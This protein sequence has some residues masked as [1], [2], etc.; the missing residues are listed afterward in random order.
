[1]LFLISIVIGIAG[2]IFSW[3]F[4]LLIGFIHNIA[5]S[6]EL[7]AVYDANIHTEGSYLG[8]LIIFAPVL[9][10]LVVVYLIKNYAPEAK[11]HGVPEVMHSIYHNR[12]LIPANVS[13]IKALASSITIGTG[14]SL[15]REGPIVQISAALSSYIGKLAKLSVSQRNLMI[16][17]GAS[18]GIAATFN[19]PLAGVLFSIELLLVAIN[20]RTIL[21]VAVATVIASNVGQY[22]IGDEPAFSIPEML[23]V[24]SG[25]G[26]YVS[27][28]AIPLG[29]IIGL[30]A[31]LFIKSIYYFED[32]FEKLPVND[33]ARHA[34]GTLLLGIM[35]Y[36]IYLRAGHYYIQGVGYATIQD[37][38]LDVI[39]D[40]GFMLLLIVTKLMATSLTI[41]S[42]GSG[43]VFSPSLFLG[44]VTGGLFGHVVNLL[45]PEL[46]LNPIVFVISGMAAMVSGTTSAPLTATIIVYEMTMDYDTILP[47]L[48]A[49]SIA[50]VVRRYFMTGDIYTLKLNR[51]GQMIPEEL[52]ADLKSHIIIDDAASKNIVFVTENEYVSWENDYACIVS[53]DKVIEIV[54]LTSQNI[55]REVPVSLLKRRKFIVLKA[56]T[57]AGK[58]V[59]Q[60][61]MSMCDVALV[62]VTGSTDKASVVGVVSSSHLINAIGDVTKTLR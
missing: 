15:G 52:V 26:V 32:L 28:L 33:Y 4:R 55:E 44:A 31:L 59:M 38:L 17:C 43:G 37:V 5:F 48:T 14:G 62:S 13:I 47:V 39:T 6:G 53:D 60:F 7:S 35:F 29:V 16:A 50:Y 46:E 40:P 23:N 2:G 18:A 41:G 1:M 12:G 22:L 42:G 36:A 49:V 56:G 30:L 8:W 58:A 9:G 61:H 24:G 20:S 27:L 45:F 21:S 19:A 25:G 34:I 57:T 11:G 51:R 10:G 54:D 3:L